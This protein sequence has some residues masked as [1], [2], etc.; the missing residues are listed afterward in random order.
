MYLLDTNVLS[1][2]TRP[3]PD[4]TVIRRLFSTSPS[5]LFASEMTR[6]ELRYGA[7]L[8]PRSEEIWQK[9]V[10][11]ILPLPLWLAIDEPIALTAGK[12]RGCGASASRSKSRTPSSP[13]P[14][15]P[16]ISCS[17]PGTF[18][19]SKSCA[20]S[21]SRTGSAK[22]PAAADRRLLRARHELAHLP[23]GDQKLVVDQWQVDGRSKPSAKMKPSPGRRM[24]RRRRVGGAASLFL[25]SLA[26]RAMLPSSSS[27]TPVA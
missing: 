20:G 23:A 24:R 5:A 18:A 27:G 11:E 4:V 19:T 9:V 10:Q 13:P 6:Y 12:L 26:T 2:L 17:S 8:H 21:R 25:M 3:R 22:P 7:A 16:A 14:R 1:E 15:S